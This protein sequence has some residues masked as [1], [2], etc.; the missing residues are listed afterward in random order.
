MPGIALQNVAEQQFAAKPHLD[1]LPLSFIHRPAIFQA[2]IAL[3][4]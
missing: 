3:S 1:A 4:C 2:G